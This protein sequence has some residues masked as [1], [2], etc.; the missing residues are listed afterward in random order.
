MTEES[1]NLQVDSLIGHYRIVSRIG[2]GGMGEVYLAEDARLE[3]KVALKI[4]L[5]EV[6]GDDE[7]IRRFVQEAKAASALNHPNILTVH[8][9]GEFENSRFIATEF[10]EGKTLRERMMG[11]PMSLHEKLGIALQAAAAL[12]AAHGAGIVHRDIKP[13]NIMLRGDGLVK[14][15]DFGLAKLTEVQPVASSSEDVTWA[16]V[17]TQPGMVIGTVAY[18]SPEQARGRTVDARSDIFSLGIVMYELFAGRPPFKGEGT[19]DLL[20]SILRDEPPSLRQIL[21]ELPRQLERIV[22]KTLRKDRDQRYQDVQDL[23]IDLEDHRDELKFEAKLGKSSSDTST[24]PTIHATDAES[25]R[26]TLL[27]PASISE[28][29]RF[30]LLHAAGFAFAA[31]GLAGAVWYLLVG[32]LE[33]AAVPDSYKVT[34]VASWS[35][36]PGELF[37]NASFSP[38]G[39][40]IAFASTKSDKKN[41][42]VTQ[43]TS[44]EAIQITNDEFSNRDP[45]WSP[46]G[47]E[48]AFFSQRTNASDAKANPTGV[49]RI[50]ALGGAPKFVGTIGD[51][52][53]ELRRWSSNGKIYYQSIGELYALDSG[54]GTS[55]KVTAFD[56]KAGVVPWINISPD[57]KSIAFVIQDGGVWTIFIGD[58]FGKNPVKVLEGPGNIGDVTWLP[59]KGRFF[60]GAI[61][62]GVYQIFLFD[63]RSKVPVRITSSETDS[64]VVDAA[65]DGSSILFSSAK[66]ESN[67]WR[68]IVS[69][70]QEAP[71]SRDLNS[72]LWPA[73]SPDDE[74]IA[75]QSVKNLSRGNKLFESDIVLKALAT[76]DDGNR[77]IRL[78]SRGFL[79]AWSPDGSA[80]AFL[81]QND[82]AIELHLVNPNGGG[83]RQMPAVGIPLIGY[84]VSPY[85]HVQTNA[86]AWS[87]D[88][89][90]IAYVSVVNGVSNIRAV[91]PGT[92][93]DE[94]LTKYESSDDSL[95][96]PIWSADGKRLAIF[97]QKKHPDA[98]GVTMR[99]LRIV[100]IE[101]GTDS[102]VFGTNEI[103]R[104]IGWTADESG[105][106]VAEAERFSGMPPETSL[107]RIAIASGIESPI[108]TLKN[109][110]FY[111]IR[112]SRD[113]K[114]IAYAARNEN[115]DDVWVSN[116]N[117]GNPRKVTRNSDSAIYFS[118]L[119]WLNDGSAVV[120]GKQSR[121][122]VLSMI[123]EI[124]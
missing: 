36:A 53:S 118:R 65:S 42:W 93:S 34:E 40:M 1:N 46:K 54:A 100:D 26:P 17:K 41:L 35:S 16:Q 24:S 82:S 69:N 30:T 116:S 14:I 8:E 105:L 32:R 111:N 20:T 109:V 7:R 23:V 4:L 29:R 55:Q 2:A 124:K 120:L 5:P 43:S 21:P 64:V 119:A 76:G 102:A 73:V 68:V 27:I 115:R 122:S 10:I 61:V 11:E 84:S 62:D 83:E 51:G 85:N 112:L 13:E 75:F 38:D 78:A 39:K 67:L 9:I 15:L 50:P 72:N 114:N 101:T 104:L 123:T 57:E 121:F 48:I 99:A 6:A 60:Y 56:R 107:K 96:C 3:R 88:G 45:I 22:D 94:V 49:W 117:G 87:P 103:I 74:A 59:D 44:T 92:M 71:L 90:K 18:M 113:R 52:S 79:P 95:Y 81:R 19:M 91:S 97:S 110:Y 77:P 63:D 98:S 66:E 86:F 106:I 108:A 28:T 89:S 31:I 70:Q 58:A 47:D 12:K 37:S 33:P 25:P 80:I